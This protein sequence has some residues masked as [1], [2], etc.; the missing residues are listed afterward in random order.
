MP[1]PRTYPEGV[2]SWVDVEEPDLEA[3]EA[4]YAGLFGWAFED[5]TPVGSPTRYAVAQLDGLAVAGLA[6]SLDSATPSWNTYVAVD[7]A[8]EAA[9]RVRAAGG[10]VLHGP[11][12]A[13]DHGRYVVCADPA[14]VPFRLRQAGTHP[15]A[16]VVNAPG[17]WNFSDLHATAP[18]AS[19]AFYTSVFPWAFDDV[20]FAAM[21][22][23]PGYGDHLAAT[24]DPDIRERQA[25]I[26]VPPG[27]ADTVGWLV[28]AAA[29]EAPHW[30]VAFTVADR[31]ATAAAAERLGGTVLRRDD[32]DWTREALIRDPQGALFTAS[33]FTPSA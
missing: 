2:P 24:I 28:P 29:E 22:R 20:G 1:E 6:G 9:R 5:V 26:G 14:G 27:F 21:I 25:G 7:D 32:T 8:E 19:A 30:H 10:Q 17:A 15:G 11:V 31:D 16:Q 33:Q 4:F 23:R 13:G 18:A 3:A 12:A